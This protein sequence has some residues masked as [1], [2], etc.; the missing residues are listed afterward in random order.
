LPLAVHAGY[1]LG[2]PVSIG[3]RADLPT[4]FEHS[5]RAPA[6]RQARQF[7]SLCA[8]LSPG[9]TLNYVKGNSRLFDW[10][11]LYRKKKPRNLPENLKEN[12]L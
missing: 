10:F 11:M 1:A 3:D 12:S 9:T 5:Q 7:G 6:F 8:V 4:I 2:Q